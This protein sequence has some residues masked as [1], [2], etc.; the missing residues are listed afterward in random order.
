[1]HARDTDKK[2]TRTSRQRNANA[3]EEIAQ[4]YLHTRAAKDTQLEAPLVISC[5]I[6]ELDQLAPHTRFK[7]NT[8][9]LLGPLD[10]LERL[11]TKHTWI[12]AHDVTSGKVEQL[13]RV[14]RFA[15]PA[16]KIAFMLRDSTCAWPGCGQ[17]AALTQ[18]HHIK[19]WSHGGTTDTGNLCL[20]CHHHHAINDDSR[21]NDWSIDT[22]P[23][24]SGYHDPF[25]SEYGSDAASEPVVGVGHEGDVWGDE[26]HVGGQADLFG[27]LG[28]QHAGEVVHWYA[29]ALCGGVVLGLAPGAVYIVHEKTFHVV[30]ECL[31]AAVW[32]FAGDRVPIHEKVLCLCAPFT[33]GLR[34]VGY[35]VPPLCALAVQC[36][37]MQRTRLQQCLL[38]LPVKPVSVGTHGGR[39]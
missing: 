20:L 14:D 9:Q 37:G 3:L 21:Q 36:A 29:G 28:V 11:S 4:T 16:Q 2:Q 19:A 7:T 17:P 34:C 12:A 33:L 31:S 27:H 39:Y 10:V 22:D 6:N 25:G 23:D 18:V 13:V 8:G 32:L 24:G 26:G 15:S 30:V 38:F 5:T 35:E 1:M